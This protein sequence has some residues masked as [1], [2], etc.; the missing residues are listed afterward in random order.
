M[1]SETH[2]NGGRLRQSLRWLPRVL[3]ALHVL[4]VL[5]GLQ[6]P[7][8]SPQMALAQTNTLQIEVISARDEPDHPDGPV[9]R[10]DEVTEY[11]YLINVDNTG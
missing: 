3:I 8:S 9:L 6:V 2:R 5:L 4:L 10:G 7:L 1:I 11:K